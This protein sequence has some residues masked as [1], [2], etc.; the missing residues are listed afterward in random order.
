M[1]SRSIQ[2]TKV[3][4]LKQDLVQHRQAI[5][6]IV[7]VPIVIASRDQV[8]CYLRLKL[9]RRAIAQGPAEIGSIRSGRTHPD[10]K[11]PEIPQLP[12]SP[13]RSR[14]DDSSSTVLVRR[15]Y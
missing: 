14:T 9:L 12:S 4:A 2:V 5:K 7:Q 11:F 1:G 6:T 10:L 3:N 8:Q 13:D 15:Q